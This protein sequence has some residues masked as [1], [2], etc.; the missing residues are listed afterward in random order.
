[1]AIWII[2]HTHSRPVK[3]TTPAK[4]NV[5]DFPLDMF[6]FDF[7]IVPAQED[8][9]WIKASVLLEEVV[10]WFYCCCSIWK[11]FP[12]F[13]LLGVRLCGWFPLLC[14]PGSPSSNCSYSRLIR[15][16]GSKSLCAEKFPFLEKNYLLMVSSEASSFTTA[17]TNSTIGSMNNSCC[18]LAYPPCLFPHIT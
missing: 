5:T 10:T 1:M 4:I 18:G 2:P 7:M 8:C 9:L 16:R 6:I 3:N 15:R 12:L 14:L 11:W 17:A 13:L